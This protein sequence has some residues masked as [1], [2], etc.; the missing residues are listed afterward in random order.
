MNKS[1]QEEYNKQ[2][3]HKYNQD[4][5]RYF[6]SNGNKQYNNKSWFDRQSNALM[7]NMTTELFFDRNR[8]SDSNKLL[9]NIGVATDLKS[10][11]APRM[12]IE[13][14]WP[15]N[16]QSGIYF[17][18]SGSLAAPPVYSKEIT[19]LVPLEDILGSVVACTLGW[20]DEPG[21][22]VEVSAGFRRAWKSNM[23]GFI[24]INYSSD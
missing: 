21:S 22:Q 2:N 5:P 9:L 24:R 8:N 4:K 11:P 14:T 3:Y 17:G 18:V 13:S 7:V 16:K 6:K 20:Q 10:K 19:G 12:K 1:N 15:L 23:Y